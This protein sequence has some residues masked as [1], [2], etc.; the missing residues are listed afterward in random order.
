[1]FIG[2]FPNIMKELEH[3]K[4]KVRIIAFLEFL[5]EVEKDDRSLSFERIA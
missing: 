4:Q 1:V 2:R 5:F 3:L